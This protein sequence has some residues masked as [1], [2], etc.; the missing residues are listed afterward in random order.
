MPKVY[1]R[2]VPGDDMGQLS[3]RLTEHKYYVLS[4]AYDLLAVMLADPADSD[5]MALSFQ[6]GG[7]KTGFDRRTFLIKRIT[8]AAPSWEKLIAESFFPDRMKAEYLQLLDSRLAR[9]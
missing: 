2:D 1:R 7:N 9:L 5:E 6:T 4:P 8:S 3:N